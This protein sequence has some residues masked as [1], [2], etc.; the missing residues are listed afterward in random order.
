MPAGEGDAWIV[1]AVR[2][3]GSQQ[4]HLAHALLAQADPARKRPDDDFFRHFAYLVWRPLR[5]RIY[6]TLTRPVWDQYAEAVA[7]YTRMRLGGLFGW[8][9][10]S[11]ST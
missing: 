9:D 4:A 5:R 1:E 6:A 7:A 11:S 3:Y 2:G 10:R 8:K